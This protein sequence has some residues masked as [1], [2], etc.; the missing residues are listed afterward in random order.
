MAE[1]AASKATDP[2]LH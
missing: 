1:T 2:L